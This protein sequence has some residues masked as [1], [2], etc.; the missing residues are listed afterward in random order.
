M[1]IKIRYTRA[2]TQPDFLAGK[3][4]DVRELDVGY[5]NQL[6]GDGYAVDAVT[7]PA[8]SQPRPASPPAA[9]PDGSEKPR[10]VEKPITPTP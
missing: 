1:K 5:A 3:P 6:I 10:R 2:V 4:G 7:P 8:E 9:S